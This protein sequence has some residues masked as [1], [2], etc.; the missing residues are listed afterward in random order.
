MKTKK[1]ITFILLLMVTILLIS[2][3]CRPAEKPSPD[4][5]VQDQDEIDRYIEEENKRRQN[6]EGYQQVVKAEAIA[7]ALVDQEGIYD[8]TVVLYNGKALVG[9]DV[10]EQNEGKLSENLRDRIMN[11]IKTFDNEI[12][13]VNITTN[14]DLFNRIDDIEQSLMKGD[15]KI[16]VSKEIDAIIKKIK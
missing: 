3:G 9:V 1:L 8:A 16:N 5:L 4:N 11:T 7:D 15:T 10:A 13:D 12:R 2:V 14:S 6:D